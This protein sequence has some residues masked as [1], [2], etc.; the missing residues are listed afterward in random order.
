MLDTYPCYTTQ[1]LTNITGY[2]R[3]MIYKFRKLGLLPPPLRT[4][5]PYAS[6]GRVHVQRL[7]ELRA[8]QEQNRTWE[9]VR[10]LLSSPASM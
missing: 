6:W 8:I 10:D 2:S 5:P 1:D 4:G 3:W 7:R 9:D